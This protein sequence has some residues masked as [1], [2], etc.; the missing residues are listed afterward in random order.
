[1]LGPGAVIAQVLGV[2][3][4]QQIGQGNIA[5][6][7]ALPALFAYDTQ[8]GCD[9]VPVGLAL[10]EAKPETIQVG[11]PAVLISRQVMGPISVLIG[12]LFSFGLY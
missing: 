2:L 11:V 1:M 4:G 6:Q 8:V 3:I 12:W 7:Y 10:G 5:P 9:F